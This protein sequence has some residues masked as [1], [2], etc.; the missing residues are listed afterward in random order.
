MAAVPRCPFQGD[1]K[2]QGSGGWVSPAAQGAARLPRLGVLPAGLPARCCHQSPATHGC[3]AGSG[4]AVLCWVT[5][6]VSFLSDPRWA[7]PHA[8]TS[9]RGDTQGGLCSSSLE[10]KYPDWHRTT[11]KSPMRTE[12]QL[13]ATTELITNIQFLQPAVNSRQ[14]KEAATAVLRAGSGS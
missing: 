2:T 12:G 4:T 9:K 13:A 1:T 3:A 10:Q 14:D 11:P 6:A 8:R 7:S 5:L